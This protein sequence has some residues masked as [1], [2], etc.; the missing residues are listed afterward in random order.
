MCGVHQFGPKLCDHIKKKGYYWPV[1]VYDYIDFAKRCDACLFDANFIH[2]PP[3]PLHP[4]VA[5]WPFMAWGLDVV[6]PLTP[7]SSVGHLYI[8]AANNYFSK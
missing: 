2:Q 8:I 1:I 6:G 3:G 4:T 7:K 5:S